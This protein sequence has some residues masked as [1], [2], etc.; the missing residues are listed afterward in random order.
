MKAGGGLVVVSGFVVR[1]TTASEVLTN[2]VEEDLVCTLNATAACKTTPN[3]P[4]NVLGTRACLDASQG[5][6]LWAA[7][8]AANKPPDE[9]LRKGETAGLTRRI[10]T[11]QNS[12]DM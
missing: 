4:L 3:E 12:A 6:N 11:P 8:E 10:S 1:S 5:F 9:P 7:V 2:G